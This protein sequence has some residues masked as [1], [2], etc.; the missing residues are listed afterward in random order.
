MPD[1][2]TD[3]VRLE[4]LLPASIFERFYPRLAECAA[5]GKDGLWPRAYRVGRTRGCRAPR[6]SL[7]WVSRHKSA[8][9]HP[10]TGGRRIRRNERKYVPNKAVLLLFFFTL[11]EICVIYHFFTFNSSKSSAVISAFHLHSIKKKKKT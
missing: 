11:E 10:A 9:V 7:D 3:A 2:R 4:L 1:R 8:I 6:R 5:L